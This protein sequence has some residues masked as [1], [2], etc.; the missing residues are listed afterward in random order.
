MFCCNA[1]LKDVRDALTKV[2]GGKV[3]SWYCTGKT[4]RSWNSILAGCRKSDFIG[5][6][7]HEQ[8]Y[9][10]G[11]LLT[12][13]EDR[14][15]RCANSET[16][17][18]RGR[19]SSIKV[20]GPYDST[21]GSRRVRALACD[22]QRDCLS[23]ADGPCCPTY[24][25][26]RFH[27]YNRTLFVAVY[28]CRCRRRHSCRSRTRPILNVPRTHTSCCPIPSFPWPT[29]AFSCV[30][31]PVISPSLY[32]SSPLVLSDRGSFIALKESDRC[33]R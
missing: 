14:R 22:A 32:C 10:K 30:S 1:N 19:S 15:Y 33:F 2:A 8:E 27:S 24:P 21:I 13:T 4:T 20:Y 26:R 11:G 28:R 18:G 6:E 17:A 9:V 25:S 5:Q 29:A 7:G 3:D 16:T 12:G 31:S 23:A